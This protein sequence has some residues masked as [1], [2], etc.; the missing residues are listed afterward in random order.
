MD[1]LGF[2]IAQKP[3]QPP[4]QQIKQETDREIQATKTVPAPDAR[5]PA[6]AAPME[7]GRLVTD[8][9][10]ACVTRAPP[11]SQF[12]VKQWTVHNADE[13]MRISRERQAETTGHVL[14]TASTEVPF[15]EVQSCSPDQCSMLPTTQPG[16]IGITRIEPVPELFGTFMFEPT[17]AALRANHNK[18][19]LNK[20][21]LYGRNTASRW[22]HLY[23]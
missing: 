17:L 4:P 19:D 15:F 18:L 2:R 11:G 22:T 5:Y 16:G 14:G 6:F 7:D 10:Q 8:Y 20:E 21:V 12:G 9:R 3:W 13:I 23:A 1:P